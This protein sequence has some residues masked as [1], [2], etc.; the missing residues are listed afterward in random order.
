[1]KLEISTEEY[2]NVFFEEWDRYEMHVSVRPD[3]S[4]MVE[5]IDD[6]RENGVDFRYL[7][8]VNSDEVFSC[9]RGTSEGSIWTE[10]ERDDSVYTAPKRVKE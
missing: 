2:V 3:G 1:M 5:Y 4:I 10:W 8:Y 9:E 7:C 6:N